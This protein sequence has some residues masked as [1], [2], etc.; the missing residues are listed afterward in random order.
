MS[1]E[2]I[3]RLL[4]E[5]ETGRSGALDE[6]MRLLYADLRAVAERFLKDRYGPGLPGATLEPAAL[7]NETYLQLL[8]QRSGYENRAHFIAIASRVMLR[9]LADYERTK[10]RL[11][12]GGDQLRVTLTG[13][14]GELLVPDDAS[15]DDFAD[16]LEKLD[17]LDARS[18][19]V[20]RLHVLWGRTAGEIAGLLAV[21][22]RT[23]ERDLRFARAW[24]ADALGEEAV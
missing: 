24:L 5:A 21:S 2:A 7:V 1:A 14:A 12:R 15:I 6:V 9:V 13:V 11:K 22:E 8:R 23:V 18:A 17:A 10:G 3:T 4:E 16:A 20:V 19:E